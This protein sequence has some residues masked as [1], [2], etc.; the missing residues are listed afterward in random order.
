MTTEHPPSHIF[1]FIFLG[2][3]KVY[4]NDLT[5]HEQEDC[6]DDLHVDDDNL[7]DEDEDD[8]FV[9]DDDDDDEMTYCHQYFFLNLLE[10]CWNI[11]L[12]ASNVDALDDYLDDDDDDDDDDYTVI[13]MLIMFKDHLLSK[14]LSLLSLSST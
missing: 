12:L 8:Y 11:E 6:D 9:D 14:S 2:R 1:I 3:I 10:D 5:K 7:D 13:M 4:H